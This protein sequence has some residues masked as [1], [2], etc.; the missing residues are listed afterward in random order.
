M[1]INELLTLGGA[2]I[3]VTIVVEVIKRALAMSEAAIT[4]FGPLLAVVV[5]IVTAG[6]AA[7][8][9]PGSDI[10]SAILTGLLAGAS[11]S[12]IYSFTKSTTP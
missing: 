6:L 1:A 8:S 5:G 3:I 11:A 4:R 9:L 7:V 10:S 12:G 2:A